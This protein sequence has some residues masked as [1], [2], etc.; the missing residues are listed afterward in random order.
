MTWSQGIAEVHEALRASDLQRVA[1][2]Q[3]AGQGWIDEARQKYATAQAISD[4]DPSTAYVTAYDAARFALVGVLA[5]QGL[6]ATQKGGHATVDRIIHA[7]FGRVFATFG[8][9][10]RR[11]NELEYPSY[12]GEELQDDEVDEALKTTR[13]IIDDAERVLPHL[14]MFTDTE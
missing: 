10:R 2:G 4:E 5:H 7:Q 12:P 3:A 11:R 6:R 1:G 8:T 13:Q 14:T 9:L